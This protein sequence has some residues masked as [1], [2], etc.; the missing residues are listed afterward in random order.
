MLTIP[1]Y[2]TVLLPDVTFYFRKEVIEGWEI[3]DL[4]VG[5]KL[6]FAFLS[7]DIDR[8][9]ITSEHIYP[10]GVAAKIESI[11]SDGNVKVRTYDRVNILRFE[12]TDEGQFESESEVSPEINDMDADDRK[13]CFDELKAVL[14]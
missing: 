2:D 8:E 9:E 5:E 4:D 14:P 1:L 3:E 12:R 6:I 10:I 7:N 11:D 13:E